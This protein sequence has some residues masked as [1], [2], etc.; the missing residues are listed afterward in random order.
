MGSLMLEE[1]INLALMENL[2]W[3]KAEII[4]DHKKVIKAFRA[5]GFEP[6]AL[7][8]DYFLRLDGVTHDVVL[9]MRPVVK[10]EEAEF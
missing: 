5:Q 1:L 2:Q 10:K 7:L 8:D 4:A 6:K 3:L 9:M